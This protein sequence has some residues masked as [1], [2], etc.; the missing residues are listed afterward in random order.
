MPDGSA[1]GTMAGTLPEVEYSMEVQWDKCMVRI[2]TK[3]S[4]YSNQYPEKH[5]E[6]RCNYA[7]QVECSK[8]K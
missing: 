5:P 4:R 2:T 7:Y 3:G 1:R 6:R 8:G